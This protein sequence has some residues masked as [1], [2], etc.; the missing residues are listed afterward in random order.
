MP[1][2]PRSGGGI[3]QESRSGGTRTSS[4]TGGQGRGSNCRPSAFR[5]DISRVGA[6]CAG[7]MR[8]RQSL[9]VAG[10]C[11]CCCHCQP[12]SA[13]RT[14][15]PDRSPGLACP[16]LA[17]PPY[18]GSAR[19]YLEQLNLAQAAR[20]GHGTSVALI[21]GKLGPRYVVGRW[22]LAVSTRSTESRNLP[23]L[24]GLM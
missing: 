14:G 7:V 9:L 20:A 21:L 10:G 15:C 5:P 8:P 12:R 17:D 16:G 18:P 23:P 11:C 3:Y 2:E 1:A 4:T 22:L 24:D 19:L 13:M 6:G